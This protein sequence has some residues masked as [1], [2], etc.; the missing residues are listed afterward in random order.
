MA[1][2]LEKVYEEAEKLSGTDI[3]LI[4]LGIG[5]ILGFRIEEDKVKVLEGWA[6]EE[7]LSA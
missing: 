1:G 5:K 4:S 6:R 3:T 2:D 7:F